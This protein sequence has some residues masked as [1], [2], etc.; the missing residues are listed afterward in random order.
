MPAPKRAGSVT[1]KR[2]SGKAAAGASPTRSPSSLKQRERALEAKESSKGRTGKLGAK[3]ASRKASSNLR[4]ATGYESDAPATRNSAAGTPDVPNSYDS[5][6]GGLSPS[7]SASMTLPARSSSSTKLSKKGSSRKA[8]PTSSRTSLAATGALD[9]P[10]AGKAGSSRKLKKASSS[11]KR[12]LAATAPAGALPGVEWGD[13]KKAPEEK[14]KGAKKK[15]AEGAEGG[16][17]KKKGAKGSKARTAPDGFQLTPEEQEY[18]RTR[19]VE[20][21]AEEALSAAVEAAA[22]AAA[23][24]EV[25]RLAAVAGLVRPLV[26][27]VVEAD[28]AERAEREAAIQVLLESALRYAEEKAAERAEATATLQMFA[29]IKEERDVDVGSADALEDMLDELIPAIEEEQRHAATVV[30]TRFRGYDARKKYLRFLGARA[31]QCAV[32]CFVARRTLR[33]L[34][35]TAAATT[36]QRYWRGFEGR[37]YAAAIREIENARRREEATRTIQRCWRGHLGRKEAAA[38]RG[39]ACCRNCGRVALGSIVLCDSC[40]DA[41]H[42]KCVG[43]RLHGRWQCPK[44]SLIPTRDLT[45]VKPPPRPRT[46]GGWNLPGAPTKRTHAQ[47]PVTN[48]AYIHGTPPRDHD[49]SD[50]EDSED[51]VR[52]PQRQPSRKA[53]WLRLRDT[54][55]VD[56]SA[57]ERVLADRE[58]ARNTPNLA[59]SDT[60]P[61]G[62]DP[63]QPPLTAPPQ[64]P[65]GPDLSGNAAIPNPWTADAERWVADDVGAAQPAVEPDAKPATPQRPGSRDARDSLKIT[66]IVERSQRM[67]DARQK[68]AFGVM[69]AQQAEAQTASLKLETSGHVAAASAARRAPHGAAPRGP[70]MLSRP[71]RLQARVQSEANPLLRAAQKTAALRAALLEDLGAVASSRPLSAFRPREGPPP[72]AQLAGILEAQDSQGSFH[73]DGMVDGLLADFSEDDLGLPSTADNSLRPM[74]ALSDAASREEHL[75]PIG[76]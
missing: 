12:P 71:L 72:V 1:R 29:R 73:V 70:A 65:A 34:R 33:H 14:K 22:W 75:P 17:K 76:A 63:R 54:P 38:L 35:R 28:R 58:R 41:Y 37:R 13:A 64:Q 40:N 52:P 3:K 48:I 53:S 27:A 43:G 19:S 66:K 69:L 60:Y 18:V 62:S 23:E 24:E 15:K 59:F 30:Q 16:G 51:D 42:E 67:K 46:G 68:V 50:A 4:G 5:D 39:E 9:A 45:I 32:R 56:D 31:V 26:E 47:S 36:I 7:R 10:A 11:S 61:R 25:E 74:D 6:A 8:G 44:C 49:P 20:V 57:M 21:G 55:D 2:P